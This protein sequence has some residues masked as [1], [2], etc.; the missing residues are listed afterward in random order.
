MHTDREVKSNRPDIIIKDRVQ[1]TCLLID[2]AIPSERNT[3]VK[4]VEKLSKYKDL[5]EEVTRMWGL[6]QELCPQLLGHSA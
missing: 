1:K 6:E 5:E 4:V 2:M 3:S